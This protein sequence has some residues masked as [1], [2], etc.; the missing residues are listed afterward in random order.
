[1]GGGG[2]GG[3]TK[4]EESYPPKPTEMD[5]DDMF[6]GIPKKEVI[7]SLEWAIKSIKGKRRTQWFCLHKRGIKKLDRLGQGNSGNYISISDEQVSRYVLFDIQ[8]DTLFCFG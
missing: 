3:N 7:F 6:W 5:M 4:R 2:G 8:E 1:M